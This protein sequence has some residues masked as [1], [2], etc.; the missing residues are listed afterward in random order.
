MRI[1][2]DNVKRLHGQIQVA[3]KRGLFTRL[4]IRLPLAAVDA[5]PSDGRP[6]LSVRRHRTRRYDGRSA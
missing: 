3:T 6:G 1:L 5:L 4:R 2:R